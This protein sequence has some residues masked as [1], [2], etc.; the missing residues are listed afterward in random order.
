MF[1]L[2]KITKLVG[3]RTLKTAIG[4]GLAVFIAQL[5]NL[6]YGV[7]AGIVVILSLQNTKKKSF[8]LA[9]IRISATFVALII[10]AVVYS[11]LGFSP[12]AFGIY[13]LLFIPV[14]VKL[15]L[16]DGIVPA[17]VLV[18]H[19]LASKDISVLSLSNE[20]AQMLIG[21]GIALI[22]NMYMPGL[23]KHIEAD[24]QGIHKTKILLIEELINT[25]EGQQNDSSM[26]KLIDEIRLR[27]NLSDE[28]INLDEKEY[29]INELS[30]FRNKLK[31]EKQVVESILYMI[32][33]AKIINENNYN[34]TVLIDLTKE[35]KNNLVFNSSNSSLEG[36]LENYLNSL[37]SSEHSLLENLNKA[38]SYQ[39]LNELKF[40]IEDY[41]R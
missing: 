17:S 8:E 13:L 12:L 19:L 32:R 6:S 5:L 18:S 23:K 26:D 27:V 35:F 9:G 25:L 7:N 15:K 14:A 11:I 16:N 37:N 21:A 1:Y 36:K 39:Y 33:I 38:I 3:L 29:P 31:S 24:F 22:L 2:N 20:M 28:R 10:G 41:I 30:T 40:M 4:A 34:N